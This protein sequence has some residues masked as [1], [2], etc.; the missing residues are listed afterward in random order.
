[1]TARLNRQRPQSA[2]DL[3]GEQNLHPRLCLRSSQ[4]QMIAFPAI[5]REFD[6]IDRGETGMPH[7]ENERFE[8]IVAATCFDDRRELRRC[9]RNH[10][11]IFV[12]SNG[13]FQRCCWTLGYPLT[14]NGKIKEGLETFCLLFV[15]ELVHL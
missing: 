5:W 11:Y 14:G 13:R 10:R 12:C 1:M 7:N 8:V 6:A 4:L 3:R 15:G 2:G 9:E